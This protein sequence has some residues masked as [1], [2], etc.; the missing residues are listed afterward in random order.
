M[1]ISLAAVTAFFSATAI[2]APPATT[3]ATCHAAQARTQPKTAMG[4]GIELPP[5]QSQLIAHPKLTYDRDGYRYTIERKDGVS[6]YTVSDGATSLT[7]PIRYAFGAHMQTFVFDYEGR[8]YESQV[9][10]F[11]RIQGLGV[12][13]GD[14][15]R[16]PRTLVEAMGRETL[17]PE[18]TACFECHATNAVKQ[19]KLTLDTLRPGL[20]CDHCHNG[21]TAHMDA[22]AQGKSAPILQRLG[23]LAAEDMSTF[24]GKCHRTWEAIVQ[25]RQFGVKNV[26][27][28]PYRI[29]NSKC[30]LGD[31]KRIRCTAC[32]NPHANLAE[33]DTTYDAA[34]QSCHAKQFNPCPVAAS[35]CATCHMPKIQAPG[36]EAIFTDHQIRIVRPGDPYPN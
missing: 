22:L 15:H 3:C 28:Q 29:A 34:C 9:S 23:A 18:I 6:L 20:D 27:F 5:D 17:N 36:T 14:E 35:K 31:D 11:P 10:Y 16:R 4:I 25:M 13:L 21:A 12:T 1:R 19:G 33:G 24:C 30:F 2:A 32:H 7:L 26:R 8:F